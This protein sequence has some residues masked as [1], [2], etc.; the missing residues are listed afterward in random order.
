MIGKRKDSD[1]NKI[2][3]EDLYDI[4]IERLSL[5]DISKI[6]V[7]LQECEKKQFTKEKKM[8]YLKNLI[9][10][11]SGSRYISEKKFITIDIELFDALYEIISKTK[12]DKDISLYSPNITPIIKK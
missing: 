11:N 1:V 9:N 10:F 8:E 7:L 4:H 12:E 2:L 3:N 5:E 6:D